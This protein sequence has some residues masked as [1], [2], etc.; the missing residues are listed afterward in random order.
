MNAA[1]RLY[2]RF[3]P[4][5]AKMDL[6]LRSALEGMLASFAMVPVLTPE[7]ERQINGEFVG[8]DGIENRGKLSNLLESEWLLRELDPDDF[9]RRIAEGEVMFR[10]R[11]FKGTGEKDVL[12]AVLDCGPWML[13][14]NR[15]IALASLF[16]L[17]LRADRIGAQLLWTVPGVTKGWSEDLTA[18]NI[19]IFLG[20][21]VQ[22]AITP[23]FIDA[24]LEDFESEPKEC[25]YVGAAQSENLTQH[26]D[27]TGSIIIQ[28]R[29]DV[30]DVAVQINSRGRKT[31]LSIRPTKDDET[32]AAL[33]RPFMP[34]RMKKTKVANEK[35]TLTAQPFHKHWLID[36]F[37]H[38]VLIRFPE[39][40][41]WYPFQQERVPT[42][43]PNSKGK[44]L[45]GVQPQAKG[46]ISVL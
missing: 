40:V 4:L 18:D 34:E 26:P 37:N 10:R 23:A 46:K 17:A 25:W 14:N 22:G 36:R 2:A 8:F 3:A 12:C 45:L 24:A 20:R 13:G 39:G 43:I 21:I 5:F 44:I 29:Y 27:I 7:D 6:P 28:N 1:P 38:A 33:R 16:H 35:E 19:R 32:V 30:D 41:L 15:I 42:W 31:T 11:D 9:V